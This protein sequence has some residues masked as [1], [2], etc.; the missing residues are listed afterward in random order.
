[1]ALLVFLAAGLQTVSGFGFALLAMPILTLVLG[2]RIAAP[3]IAMTGVTLY[4][5]NLIRYRQAVN[6]PEVARLTVASAVGVPVG[7]RVFDNANEALIRALLGGLLI[8]YAL[9]RQTRP[10][11]RHRVG[12]GWV[13]GA[14]F[15]AGCLG[16]AYNTPG[17]P[18]IVYGALR[19]WPKQSFKGVLQATFL[20]NGALV[21]ASHFAARHLTATVLNLYLWAGPAL[22]L[23]VW[24]GSG[25]D[26]RLNRR[27][28]ERVV[29]V[30]IFLLGV[31]LM[32]T[33]RR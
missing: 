33:A 20:V 21:V 9:Y 26:S 16:G 11:T 1:M 12:A 10:A 25:L 19:Q 13:F 29:T 31:S 4:A 30:V 6:W 32:A 3:L 7:I 28:F 17:P 24:V 15:L 22:L 8:A 23:G 5:V 18:V 2:L 14:G 27:W